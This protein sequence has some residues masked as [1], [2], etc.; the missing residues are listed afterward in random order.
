MINSP[1]E[2]IPSPYHNAVF[3]THS[4]TDSANADVPPIKS[5]IGISAKIR[6][7]LKTLQ[8]IKND[9][10]LMNPR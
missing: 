4:G 1:S 9:A 5:T 6:T 7:H 8:Y 2:I 10:M 3:F